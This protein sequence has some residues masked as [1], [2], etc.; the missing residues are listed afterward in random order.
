MHTGTQHTMSQDMNECI[1]N[2][3]DCHRSCL[4]TAAHCLQMGGK[5]ADAAHINLLTDCATI[6]ATSANFMIRSS[7]F[8]PQT[9]GVCAA[10]C[11]ACADACEQM[12]ADDETMKQCAEI[13]RRCAESCRQMSQMAAM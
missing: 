1:Q 12:G 7:T 9:C 11:A 13:C 8:H 2:C 5:H 6:C 3:L 4:E 10:V